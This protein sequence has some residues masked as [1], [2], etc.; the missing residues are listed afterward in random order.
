MPILTVSPH[1]I[2]L[3]EDGIGRGSG[4][5]DHPLTAATFF[6]IV[7]SLWVIMVAVRV[8]VGR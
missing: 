2:S 6:G 7:S 8:A 4:S 5:E 3:G 1:H